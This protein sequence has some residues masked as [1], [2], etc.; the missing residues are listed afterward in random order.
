MT[1]IPLQQKKIIKQVQ[2]RLSKLLKHK[3]VLLLI[4]VTTAWF[5]IHTI[6]IITDGLR[7]DDGIADAI[8]VLGNK[9]EK[10][11]VPSQRLRDRLN[12][13]IMIFQDGRAKY[14]IVSGG[15]GAEGYDEAITM[16]NYLLIHDIPEICI[17][18]D[19]NG[20]NARATAKFTSAVF[21]KKIIVQLLL[22]L[23]TLIFHAVN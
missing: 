12:K 4:I 13:A 9:V 3:F 2:M 20:V 15:I 19:S 11:G 8:V 17:I 6:V 16:K 7:P 22:F 10:N 23:N 5:I 21:R 14:I 1:K 18:T